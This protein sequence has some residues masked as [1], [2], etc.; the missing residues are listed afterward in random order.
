MATMQAKT[1]YWFKP[2]LHWNVVKHDVYFELLRFYPD[3]YFKK[4]MEKV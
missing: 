3:G 1:V 2:N 4:T